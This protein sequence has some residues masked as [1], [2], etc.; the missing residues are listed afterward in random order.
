MSDLHDILDDEARRVRPATQTLSSVL[1]RAEHRRRV[2]RFAGGA[3]ALAIAAVGIAMASTAFDLGAE[4]R[5]GGRPLPGPTP[6]ATPVPRAI[7]GLVISNGSTF[8]GAAEFAA[9][10]LQGKGVAPEAV[11]LEGGSGSSE[12]TTISCRPDREAEALEL[13]DRFF[14]GAEIRPRIDSTLLISIGD[15]YVSKHRTLFD[16]FMTVRSFMTRRVEGSGAEAFLSDEAARRFEDG[17]PS[18]YAYIRGGTFSIQVL[19]PVDRSTAMAEVLIQT[20]ESS[21]LVSSERLTVGLSDGRAMILRAELTSPVDP[22]FEQI[23][24][25]VRQFLRARRQASGAGTFLGPD[26]REAYAS[27]EDGLNLLAYAAE[28]D[29]MRARIVGFDKL[30]AERTLVMVRFSLRGRDIFERLTVDRL[31]QTM[32]VIADAERGRPA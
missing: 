10:I 32:L 19:L 15:D 7:P 17:A 8:E 26:A 24:V 11:M 23:S 29:L 18:L 28:G 25:F 21:D 4:I 9:A 5:L 14:P 31:G 30:S 3:V 20:P 27:G 12:T 22:G 2:R 16:L 1:R 13:R 6:S